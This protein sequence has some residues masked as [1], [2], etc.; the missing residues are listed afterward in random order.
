MLQMQ[1]IQYPFSECF[2][3]YFSSLYVGFITPGRIGEL[4]KV[5]YLKYDLKIPLS[6]GFSSVILDRILDFYLLIIL[7]LIGIQRFSI[8]GE[9]S[10]LVPFV[11]ITI[12]LFPLIFI[13]KSKVTK[14]AQL[15][16]DLVFL[17][18]IKKI[19]TESFE[20]FHDGINDLISLKIIKSIILTIISYFIFF[21]QCFLLTKAMN[22]QIDFFTLVLFMSISNLFSFI[23]IS[24]SGLGTRDAA[25]IY[26][27]SLIGLQSELA[28]GYAFLVFF[29][30]FVCGGIMGSIAWVIKP[31]KFKNV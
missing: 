11:L 27:F 10:F 14:F 9:L 18:K 12:I 8:G 23:P 5:L 1:N 29:S 2:L 26:L 30:F 25:L 24:I 6:K 16:Y 20:E 4:V 19:F 17:K 3:A 13:S 31:I 21:I 22:L 28:V 15:I 7:G